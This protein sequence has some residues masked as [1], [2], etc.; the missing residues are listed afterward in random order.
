MRL[1]MFVHA[2]LYLPSS[3]PPLQ[4]H[5]H[6]FAIGHRGGR[7]GGPALEPN[8]DRTPPADAPMNRTQFSHI[9]VPLGLEKHLLRRRRPPRVVDG[10]QPASPSSRPR[11]TL[12]ADGA[13]GTPGPS[14]ARINIPGVVRGTPFSRAPCLYLLMGVWLAV[15]QRRGAGQERRVLGRQLVAQR[16]GAG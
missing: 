8:P 3:L 11:G 2:R 7:A 14:Q 12:G 9:T 1:T 10:P 16:E 15:G 4:A 6:A 5:P 13:D